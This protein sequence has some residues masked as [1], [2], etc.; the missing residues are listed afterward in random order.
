[1]VSCHAGFGHQLLPLVSIHELW[2]RLV[3][4]VCRLHHNVCGLEAPPVRKAADQAGMA[5]IEMLCP[6]TTRLVLPYLFSGFEGRRNWQVICCLQAV[7]VLLWFDRTLQVI[8]AG[9][10]LLH[11][12][13][14][15]ALRPLQIKA[16]ALRLLALLAKTAPSQ[17]AAELP[18]IVP[19]LSEPLCDAKLQVKVREGGKPSFSVNSSAFLSTWTTLSRL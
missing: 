3:R 18:T 5:F 17:L 14:S 8:F 9:L 4:V 6:Y 12:V 13:N 10:L 7:P 1:M 11:V 19:V 15:T 2:E 16:G